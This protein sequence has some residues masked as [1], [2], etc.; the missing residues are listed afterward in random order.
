[1]DFIFHMTRRCHSSD[2]SSQVGED[3]RFHLNEVLRKPPW[4]L[5]L[6][7]FLSVFFFALTIG[8]WDGRKSK[9]LCR[10]ASPYRSPW[11]SGPVKRVTAGQEA[12]VTWRGDYIFQ[13]CRVSRTNLYIQN[14]SVHL[15]FGVKGTGCPPP[16]SAQFSDTPC[17]LLSSYITTSFKGR[18]QR[19][20]VCP[21][22]FLSAVTTME[23]IKKKKDSWSLAR[24]QVWNCSS[25]AAFQD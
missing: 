19:F 7:L 5:S 20:C 9:W 13:V 3:E 10:S 21:F 12:Y 17:W 11:K 15:E 14:K 6:S 2:C 25:P 1:M 8:H 18:L 16:T 22:L 4:S 23:T 24:F